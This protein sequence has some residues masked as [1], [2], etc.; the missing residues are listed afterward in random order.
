MCATEHVLLSELETLFILN[1]LTSKLSSVTLKNYKNELVNLIH[2]FPSQHASLKSYITLQQRDIFKY[3]ETTYSSLQSRSNKIYAIMKICHWLTISDENECYQR[4]KTYAFELKKNKAIQDSR[5]VSSKLQHASSTATE[6]ERI[7]QIF[8]D[9]YKN[10]QE[11]WMKRLVCCTFLVF[12]RRTRDFTHM[13]LEDDGKSNALV[14][15]A[16]DP[17]FIIRVWKKGKNQSKCPNEQHLAITL[18]SDLYRLIEQ[19]LQSIPPPIYFLQMKH[20]QPATWTAISKLFERIGT[21]HGIKCSIRGLRHSTA[22]SLN[23]KKGTLKEYM[24]LAQTMGT[25]MNM[26]QKHYI[27]EKNA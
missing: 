11:S 16:I 7:Q 25:S 18:N 26:L 22:T 21:H 2:R 20:D 13:V 17:K 24:D 15:N 3:L 5:Q 14:F 8:T 12:T 1:A 19:Y 10:T 23:T 9:I 6:W 4:Y 27:E